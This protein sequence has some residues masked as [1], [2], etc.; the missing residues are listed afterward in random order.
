MPPE[1]RAHVSEVRADV[2]D[3]FRDTFIGMYAVEYVLQK[4]TGDWDIE[5]AIGRACRASA[6]TI[7]ALG[8]QETI[9]WYDEL[10]LDV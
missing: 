2:Y 7:A 6:K 1:F 8:C 9:P 5:K 10:D 3:Q 4:Q